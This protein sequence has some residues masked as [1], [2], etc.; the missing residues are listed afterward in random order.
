MLYILFIS[1]DAGGYRV[2]SNGRR[3]AEQEQRDI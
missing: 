3:A 2:L 1:G